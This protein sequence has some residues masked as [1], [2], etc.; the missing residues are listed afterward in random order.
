VVG[1]LLGLRITGVSASVGT[2]LI[3]FSTGGGGVGRG[4]G[5]ERGGGICLVLN[6]FRSQVLLKWSDA[7]F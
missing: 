2:W 7:S 5:V 4:G 6:F 1:C 3:S